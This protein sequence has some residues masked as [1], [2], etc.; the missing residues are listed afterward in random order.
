MSTEELDVTNKVTALDQKA[1][2]IKV[3]DK[4]TYISAGEQLKVI[5][6]LRKEIE[7]TFDPITKKAHA[8]WKEAIA[9][10]KKHDDPL[11]VAEK[12]IKSQMGAFI[13]AEEKRRKEEEAAMLAASQSDNEDERIETATKLEE[14]G[15]TEAAEAVL[16][17]EP[18]AL[19][20]APESDLKIAGISHC[21]KWSA[22]VVDLK[23]LVE[24]VAVGKAPSKAVI[25]DEK[26]LNKQA[27]QL[28][29]EMQYP[30]VVVKSEKIIASG[31]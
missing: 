18:A 5:K 9:Q 8:T 2:A 25:A 14:A 23:S 21:D 7:L 29:K 4:D 3:V 30:G 6:G 19:P 27:A 26:W 1:M 10:R 31:S 24:A 11:T 22:Q 12:H 17:Q 15:Q 13:D 20:P 16:N 28:Q